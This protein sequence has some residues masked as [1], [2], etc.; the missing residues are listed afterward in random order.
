MQR[1]GFRTRRALIA[2]ALPLASMAVVV[3]GTG[4]AHAAANPGPGF[5][6]H[7]SAP[8]VETWASSSAMAAA[9]SATG[10]KYFTLAFV[11]S[12]GGCSATFHGNMSIADAGWTGAVNSL[13]Y[14]GG[15]G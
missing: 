13:P 12:G 14:S 8:Y 6:A 10:N 3:G 2:A 11:I 7:Y 5:P 9:Q 4:T 1:L 15:D